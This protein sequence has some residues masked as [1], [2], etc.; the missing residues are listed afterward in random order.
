MTVDSNPNQKQVF[1]EDKMEEKF[2]FTDSMKENDLVSEWLS[3][4]VL[5]IR[6]ILCNPY[7]RNWQGGDIH[8][9]TVFIGA[10]FKFPLYDLNFVLFTLSSEFDGGLCNRLL[11]NN[12][13]ESAVSD[14]DSNDIDNEE[15]QQQQQQ[16]QEQEQQDNPEEKPVQKSFKVS[17][18]EYTTV[19]PKLSDQ[20]I[21]LNKIS[22][23][24]KISPT[25]D[26]KMFIN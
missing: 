24:L 12:E 14:V 11:N 26:F 17:L 7:R 6:V 10:L 23:I 13:D 22:Q 3:L 21:K 1:H 9:V 5:I 19:A 4:L 18:V 2:T 16:Q 25:F 15:Q 20:H 8:T